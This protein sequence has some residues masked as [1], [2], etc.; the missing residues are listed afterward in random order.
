MCLAGAA[1]RA[2]FPLPARAAGRILFIGQLGK[3]LPG[4]V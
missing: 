1:G 2:W 3:Y 4:S